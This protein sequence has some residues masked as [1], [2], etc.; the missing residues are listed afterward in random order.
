MA[1][2]ILHVYMYICWIKYRL[3]NGD[4]ASHRLL[5]DSDCNCQKYFKYLLIFVLI[6]QPNG[7]CT[8]VLCK[9]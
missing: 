6:E 7:Q 9:M 5:F 2:V 1:V 8:S 4:L 3:E